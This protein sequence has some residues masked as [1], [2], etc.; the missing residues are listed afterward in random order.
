MATEVLSAL[1]V[2]G[3]GKLDHSGLVQYFET[4]AQVQVH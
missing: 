4:L 3:S 1:N 2:A